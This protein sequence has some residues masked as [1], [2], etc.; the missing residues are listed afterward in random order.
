M[1]HSLLL[2][3]IFVALTTPLFAADLP[4]PEKTPGK[5]EP[6]LTKERLCAP[7][8]TTKDWRHVSAAAK[9]RV[10]AT[11]GYAVTGKNCGDTE[12]CE[13]DHLVSL[14]IGGSNEVANLWPQPYNG[15]VWNA[16]VKDQLENRLHVMV[17]AGGISLEEAQ[18]SIR[19]NWVEAWKQVFAKDLP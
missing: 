9:H 6:R 11:Y 2:P 17:C 5:I 4:D 14:E 15:Q 1:K 3:I 7:G 19:T 8:F 18:T 16:R 12:G 13:I 10:Y